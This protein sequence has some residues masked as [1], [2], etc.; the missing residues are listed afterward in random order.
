MIKT[1]GVGVGLFLVGEAATVLCAPFLARF[2]EPASLALVGFA[3]LATGR[4]LGA[5]PITEPTRSALG[6]QL[7][8]QG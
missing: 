4:A 2:S 7:G 6:R 1:M 5:R 8:P 3:L